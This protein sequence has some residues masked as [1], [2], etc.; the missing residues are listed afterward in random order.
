MKQGQLTFNVKRRTC[1]SID[2]SS[3]IAQYVH[4]R[5]ILSDNHKEL[6]PVQNKDI[7]IS[8]NVIIH[9]RLFYLECAFIR[10]AAVWRFALPLSKMLYTSS[11]SWTT[12]SSSPWMTTDPWWNREVWL[13][14][15]F[16]ILFSTHFQGADKENLFNNQ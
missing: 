10:V 13:W 8:N 1:L 14:T 16:P 9:N 15:I 12:S 3:F 4:A 6:M 2:Q 11:L 5:L 7:H